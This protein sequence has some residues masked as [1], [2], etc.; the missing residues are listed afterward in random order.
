MQKQRKT[1][2]IFT[3][4]SHNNLLF[5]NQKEK[6]KSKTSSNSE[7]ENKLRNLNLGIFLPAHKMT[8]VKWSN[9]SQWIFDFALQIYM[10]TLNVQKS[11]AQIL[12][13]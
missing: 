2:K 8:N 7:E 3:H 6:N 10:R 4:V 11:F 9:K 5:I 13:V 12:L 1:L